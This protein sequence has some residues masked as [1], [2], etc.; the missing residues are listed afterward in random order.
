MSVLGTQ[1]AFVVGRKFTVPFNR[2]A[3]KL[4]GVRKLSSPCIYVLIF[5]GKVGKTLVFQRQEIQRKVSLDL[6]LVLT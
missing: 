4:K 6:I 3:Q 2:R 5:E 1:V